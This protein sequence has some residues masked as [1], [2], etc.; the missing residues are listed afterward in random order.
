[1]RVTII[2]SLSA[3][4]R[5]KWTSICKVAAT[6]NLTIVHY[7]NVFFFLTLMCLP[8][9]EKGSEWIVNKTMEGKSEHQRSKF[10]KSINFWILFINSIENY[11]GHIYVLLQVDWACMSY[12]LYDYK[13][14]HLKVPVV[15]KIYSGQFQYIVITYALLP[16]PIKGEAMFLK[17]K[18]KVMLV[19]TL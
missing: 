8:G 13:Y 19:L 4:V 11:L 7:Y 6:V 9:L 1:M 10:Y 14:Y 5:T 12:L 16:S 18:K 2:F 17:N 3:P 15:I